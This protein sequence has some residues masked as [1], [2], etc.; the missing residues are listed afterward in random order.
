M[1]ETTQST[2]APRIARRDNWVQ[3]PDEYAGFRFKLWV[4]A[5]QRLWNEVASGEQERAKLALA[6]IVSEHNGW[7]DFDGQ[8]YPLASD[9]TLWDAVPTELAAVVIAA[10]NQEMLRLPNSLAPKKRR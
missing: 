9:P 6:Q 1:D 2:P 3:L 7:V 10:A 5:P 8:P 4:N